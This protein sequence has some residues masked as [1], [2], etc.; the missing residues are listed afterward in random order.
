M[1]GWIEGN[2]KFS[3]PPLSFL[4]KKGCNNR[5]RC[6]LF[7]WEVACAKN[8][9]RPLYNSSSGFKSVHAGL[10]SFW[11]SAKLAFQKCTNE[12]NLNCFVFFFHTR[13]CTKKTD[14]ETKNDFFCQVTKKKPATFFCKLVP[15]WLHDMSHFL[16]QCS[17]IPICSP[18]PIESLTNLFYLIA[19]GELHSYF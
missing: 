7:H 1:E 18:M 5:M 17:P 6:R 3:S 2:L 4:S 13:L 11:T 12:T 15:L 16:D 14:F 9:K 19:L 10:G 8:E